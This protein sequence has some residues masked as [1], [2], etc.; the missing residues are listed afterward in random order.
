MVFAMLARDRLDPQGL[1]IDIVNAPLYIL[2]DGARRA[3]RALASRHA[4]PPG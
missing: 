3:R 2:V 4:A 1:D